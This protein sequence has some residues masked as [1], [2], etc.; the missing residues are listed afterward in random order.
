MTATVDA[1]L[2]AVLSLPPADR[3]VLAEKLFDSLGGEDHF[4]ISPDW[5]EEIDRRIRAYEQ[6]K[7]ETVPADE[8]MRSLSM[9][10]KT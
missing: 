2:N 4:E 1:L 5:A 8:V 9:R 3:A 7:R 10:R 6:G